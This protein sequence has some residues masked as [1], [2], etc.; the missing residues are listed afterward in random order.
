[1]EQGVFPL[2]LKSQQWIGQ[3]DIVRQPARKLRC[4]NRKSSTAN[5]WQIEWR[6]CGRFHPA[7]KLLL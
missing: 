2:L 5:G 1:M 6:I 7:V 3:R 4:C